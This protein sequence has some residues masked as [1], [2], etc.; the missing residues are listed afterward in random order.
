MAGPGDQGKVAKSGGGE[1]GGAGGFWSSFL[2]VWGDSGGQSKTPAVKKAGQLLKQ[3]TKN[4]LKSASQVLDAAVDEKPKIVMKKRQVIVPRLFESKLG[5]KLKGGMYVVGFDNPE[6]KEFGWQLHDEIV[7]VNGRAILNRDSFAKEYT[8][9]RKSLPITFTVM[10]HVKGVKKR[11]SNPEEKKSGKDETTKK[12][13][14]T[15]IKVSE[16]Q[17]VKTSPRASRSADAKQPPPNPRHNS[18][19]SIAST[20]RL[21][22]PAPEQ[23]PRPNGTPRGS[24]SA[25]DSFRTMRESLTPD[26]DMMGEVCLAQPTAAARLQAAVEI[27]AVAK[28]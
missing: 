13:E 3:A 23:S 5:V 24:A 20:A 22:A 17:G 9:A 12:V 11:E 7:E 4:A 27:S 21:G 8:E 14:T 10:R 1:D 25:R 28:E 2:G 19:S 18:S 15:K 26:V 16:P 6:A